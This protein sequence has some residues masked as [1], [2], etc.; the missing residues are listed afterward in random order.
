VHSHVSY[1][2]PKEP[3][4]RR[5]AE[6]GPA[7]TAER[8]EVS[9]PAACPAALGTGRARPTPPPP[10]PFAPPVPPRCRS[11]GRRRPPMRARSSGASESPWFA[12]HD[13]QR[14]SKTAPAFLRRARAPSH[15]T[16]SRRPCLPL[17]RV[18]RAP[19]ESWCPPASYLHLH[20]LLL[21]LLL[22]LPL[23]CTRVPSLLGPATSPPAPRPVVACPCAPHPPCAASQADGVRADGLP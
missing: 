12:W 23:P 22:L 3:A 1:L 2:V 18:A 10:A 5:A 9:V 6:A 15:S 8:Q 14:H 16:P 20:L 7:V 13:P 4:P 21:L 17:H 11:R 19:W